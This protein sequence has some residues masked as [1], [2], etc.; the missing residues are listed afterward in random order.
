MKVKTVALFL[1]TVLVSLI[2]IVLWN[3]NRNKSK[4]LID[5]KQ[6]PEFIFETLEG[7]PYSRDSIPYKTAEIAIC[8]FDPDCHYCVDFVNDISKLS[9]NELKIP[10]IMVSSAKVDRVTAFAK[11]YNLQKFPFITVLSDVKHQFN[12]YFGSNVLP[13]TYL[14]KNSILQ[15]VFQGEIELNFLTKQ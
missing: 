6:I 7:K 9:A 2:V 12:S 3:I 15:T 11:S 8:H 10:L 13:V 1:A 5:Q 14:Y 4:L